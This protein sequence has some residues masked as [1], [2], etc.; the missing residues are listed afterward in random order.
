MRRR[1][2]PIALACGALLAATSLSA[3]AGE[4]EEQVLTVF[5]AASL[6]EVFV[7]IA[8]DFKAEHEGVEVRFSFAGSSDLV[9]QLESGAP[10]G[11]FASAN[12]TQM[13][14]ALELGVVTGE[15][16]L[17]A[18]NTLTLVTP[19]DNPADIS[20]LEDAAVSSLVICAPQ[21]PCGAATERMAADAGIELK[22]VSEENSVTDVLGKVT[23]GQADAGLVYVTDAI[24]AGDSV[25]V[26]DIAEADSVVNFYPIAAVSTDDTLAQEFVDFVMSDPSQEKLRAT[27]FG[28]P[29]E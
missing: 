26:V 12:E 16:V 21:V 2:K 24:R 3:C 18:S 27:G 14:R 15:A 28:S 17:F 10:G 13:E 19:P 4:A 9:S 23:S 25:N 6:T 1:L 11:V 5:A 8:A 7:D 22:P 20:S 29:V